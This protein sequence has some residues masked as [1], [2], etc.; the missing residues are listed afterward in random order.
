MLF[1]L[2]LLTVLG[3]A[4]AYQRIEVT[5]LGYAVQERQQTKSALQEQNRRLLYQTN[6]LASPDRLLCLVKAGKIKLVAP[7]SL[8]S[9]EQLSMQR[10]EIDALTPRENPPLQRS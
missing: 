1:V 5:R 4:L 10:Q 8:L 9:L 7:S 6:L 2:L 3:M